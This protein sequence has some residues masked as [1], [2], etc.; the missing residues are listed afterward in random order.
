G[1]GQVCITRIPMG[2]RWDA[3]DTEAK[4]SSAFTVQIDKLAPVLVT[5]NVSGVFTNLS[6][7]G[8]HVVRIQLDNKP[9]TSFRFSFKGR[10]EH[11]RLWYSPFYGSWSLWDVRPGEKCACPK[12]RASAPVSPKRWAD[13]PG[14]QEAKIY[15]SLGLLDRE[16][17]SENETDVIGRASLTGIV[18]L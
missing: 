4:E 17:L 2:E 6:L 12:A 14:T 13:S 10:G 9:L 18:S 11:L 15:N 8:D 16:I 1:V 3:N 7:A 5:T